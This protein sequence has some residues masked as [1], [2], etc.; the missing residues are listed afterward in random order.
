MVNKV[1][2]KVQDKIDYERILKLA[3]VDKVLIGYPEGLPHPDSP[4]TLD[5][6]AKIMTYGAENTE[7]R[8]FLE[9]GIALKKTDL[10]AAIGQFFESKVNDANIQAKLNQIAIIA[11]G[12]VKQ[13]VYSDFYRQNVPN[14]PSTIYKKSRRSSSFLAGIKNLRGK[15]QAGAF[16]LSDKPLIDTGVMINGL[17]YVVRHKE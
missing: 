15:R 2:L 5:E 8:P 13:L 7:P 10:K 9:E 14:K 12:G 4:Y 17:T 6:L 16:L 3:G 11:V 1:T